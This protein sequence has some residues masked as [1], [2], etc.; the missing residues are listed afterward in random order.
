MDE[1]ESE[2]AE[3]EIEEISEAGRII[4]DIQAQVVAASDQNTKRALYKEIVNLSTDYA[5]DA[6]IFESSVTGNMHLRGVT[7]E[8]VRSRLRTTYTNNQ[9]VRL[10][11][12]SELHKGRRVRER[13]HRARFDVETSQIITYEAHTGECARNI[14]KL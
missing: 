9:T 8:K 14:I 1:D 5:V 4:L 2:H 3:E 10:P 12:L 11:R 7:R 13:S 6:K